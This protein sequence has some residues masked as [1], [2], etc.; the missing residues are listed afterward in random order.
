MGD[1]VENI[2]LLLHDGQP[3][4]LG[5]LRMN[6]DDTIMLI[7]N[8]AA[9]CGVCAADMPELKT[10][11]EQLGERGLSMVVS[12]FQNTNREAPDAR[13]AEQYKTRHTLP[14]TV[15]ADPDGDLLRYFPNPGLPMVMVVDLESMELLHAARGWDMEEMDALI[16]QNL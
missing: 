8:T 11:N 15:V 12:L 9:W 14:F 3:I 16:R 10:L 2:G 5:D 6:Q 1:T 7:F 4:S 13:T